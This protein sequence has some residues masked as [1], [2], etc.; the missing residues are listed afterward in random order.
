MASLVDSFLIKNVQVSKRWLQNQIIY[1]IYRHILDIKIASK[2]NK[3]RIC[4]LS[5]YFLSKDQNQ[6]FP[7]HY[8]GK[9]YFLYFFVQIKFHI[10]TM[11]IGFP[12]P[13]FQNLCDDGLRSLETTKKNWFT[14]IGMSTQVCCSRY[15][16]QIVSYY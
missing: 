3:D 13:D 7:Y 14:S 9:K 11:K 4:I 1:E 2:Q 16:H 5:N 12:D 15:E 10:K 8:Q 6:I